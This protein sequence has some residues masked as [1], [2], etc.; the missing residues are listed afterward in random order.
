M[1]HFAK[2]DENV[3]RQVVVVNNGVI[4]TADGIESEALGQSFLNDLLGGDWVQCSYN[5]NPVNGEDRGA[6]PGIGWTW[7]G[8]RFEPP[9]QP[10]EMEQP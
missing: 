8:S 5:G 6:Y 1:A 9:A 4:A 2:V 10:E 3:V 7:T